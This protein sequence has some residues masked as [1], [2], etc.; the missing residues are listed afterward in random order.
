[1]NVLRRL[2]PSGR[3]WVISVP[4]LWLL[5]F[6]LLPFVFVLK[7][8]FA[9]PDIAQPPYTPLV[10]KEESKVTINL[11][12]AKYETIFGEAE[13][14]ATKGLATGMAES[15]YLVSYWNSL[16]LALLTT[17]FC[18]LIGYPIAYNIARADET[19]RNTLLMLVML[20]FW[21]SF[22]LR[23]YAWIGILKDNGIINNLLMSLGMI[24]EPIPMLYTQFSVMLGMVYSYLPFMILPLYSHLVK[25]D[26]R[27]FE[28]SADLGATPWRTFFSITLP[29]S[30]AGMIAGSMMVF[31]PAVG[32]FVI[33]EL[34][35]GGE[36]LMIGKKL[37]DDFGVSID[38][39]Q[40]AAV[41]VLMMILLIAPII[42]FHRFETKQREA[43]Q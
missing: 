3:T 28:A 4:Y 7:I 18:L 39:P 22:L 20:P 26:T 16:K 13:T 21:T 15:Q 19:T 14:F 24:K 17:L 34:L 35:G 37:M 25:L 42:W 1:M 40:A 27:L 41:T 29:L 38:W 12:L 32:E 11:N 6:F 31:I 9:E 5:V 10:T 2:L 23:V 33:P 43:E 36:V 8:S 30:K